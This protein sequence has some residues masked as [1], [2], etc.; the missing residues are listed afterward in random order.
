MARKSKL[1]ELMSPEDKKQE[2]E[3]AVQLY[4]SRVWFCE[5]VRHALIYRKN[6][7]AR[8][9]IYEDWRKKYGDD[10]ARGPAKYVEACVQGK[11]DWLDLQKMIANGPP[12]AE[13]YV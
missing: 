12:K 9:A 7:T 1:W 2:Y 10:R 5:H 8:R 6:P 13:D 11:A 3:W 4:E